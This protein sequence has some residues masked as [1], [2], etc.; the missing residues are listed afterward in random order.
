MSRETISQSISIV[1]PISLSHGKNAEVWDTTGK[2]Y[3]DF[4]GGIGVLNLGHCHPGVV[5]AIREQAT[6]LTHSAF[7]AAPHRPY[8][9]LM[10]RL[11]AFIPVNYPVSGMLTN[12]AAVGEH[13]ADGV[14]HWDKRCQSIHEFDVRPV[15]RGSRGKCLEDRPRRH[16]PHCS[17][18]L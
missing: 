6:K 5:E 18:R 15:R 1:H 12:S 10:D 4:V 17:D 11:T 14:V 16:R 13:A 8:I 7:N 3:I 2:R 9:E